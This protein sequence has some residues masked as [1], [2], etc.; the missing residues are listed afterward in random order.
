[1][2]SGAVEELIVLVVAIIGFV[3]RDWMAGKKINAKVD[4]VEAKVDFVS[5]RING[6]FDTILDSMPYPAWIKAVG[7]SADGSIEF[8]MLHINDAYARMFKVSNDKYYNKTDFE[9]WPKDVAHSY[10]THDL[11]AL[12]SKK[13]I[14]FTEPIS[15]SLVHEKN[16]LAN[17]FYEFEKL[18]VT[19]KDRQFIIGFM[20]PI[21]DKTQ[22]TKD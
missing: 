16:E 18:L 17:R 21:D 9:I 14:K 22:L 15:E 11:V 3:I 4:R 10:Y 2:P 1:M 13:S 19:Y 12:N 5:A 8:R 6:M 7:K 20:R